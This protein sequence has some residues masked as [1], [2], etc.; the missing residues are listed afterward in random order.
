[1]PVG[2]R[3]VASNDLGSLGLVDCQ[4]PAPE[5]VVA[6]STG[7]T[8]IDLSW[9]E[10]PDTTKYRIEYR[11]SGADGWTTEDEA[12]TETAHSVDGLACSTVYEFQVSAF[13]DGDPYDANWSDASSPVTAT[14]DDCPPVG[15]PTLEG[16]VQ[17]T[18]MELSWNG[19]TGAAK[20]QVRHRE[21][22][23]EGWTEADDTEGTSW[24]ISGLVRDKTYEFQVRSYGNGTTTLA[25]WGKWSAS[26]LAATDEAPSPTNLTV[27]SSTSRSVTLS[28]D[29]IDGAASY[30]I[31]HR[32]KGH[33]G[34]WTEEE[35]T[36][37]ATFTV[38]GLSPGTGYYFQVRATGDG[39][40]YVDL[41]PGPW[42]KSQEGATS[43]E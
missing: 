13:G 31:R 34:G 39:H 21:S 2:L 40:R 35:T 5:D 17:P 15:P 23:A 1:M 18:S 4:A 27:D 42:S 33:G 3:E 22:G 30:Q 29:A 16:S 8:S 37:E 9:D 11:S 6:T 20:Y 7:A 12:I 38:S 25:D 26:L 32:V 24:T 36:A 10:V 19:V 14:T 41:R 43:A 28:W